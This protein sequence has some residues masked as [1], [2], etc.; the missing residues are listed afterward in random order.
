MLPGGHVLD[1]QLLRH[2]STTSASAREE[3]IAQ[4]VDRDSTSGGEAKAVAGLVV[5]RLGVEPSHVIRKKI[6]EA[7]WVWEAVSGEV[8]RV[9]L[10]GLLRRLLPSRERITPKQY[11]EEV[12]AVDERVIEE[13]DAVLS[14]LAEEAT[15]AV[16]AVKVVRGDKPEITTPVMPDSEETYP[17]GAAGAAALIQACVEAD[18]GAPT[19]HEVLEAI[20]SLGLDKSVDASVYAKL[21]SATTE[22]GDVEKLV[23]L[24]INNPACKEMAKSAVKGAEK[25]PVLLSLA[26][27]QHNL[28][29]FRMY[30]ERVG[31]KANDN[32]LFLAC[33]LVLGSDDASKHMRSF[34]QSEIVSRTKAPAAS[35]EDPWLLVNRG[36]ERSIE[37]KAYAALR[38]AL[39]EREADAVGSTAV[40]REIVAAN[41]GL[42][43]WIL[44]ASGAVG[45]DLQGQCMDLLRMV[46]SKSLLHN[47]AV[48][49][50]TGAAVAALGDALAKCEDDRVVGKFADTVVGAAGAGISDDL[51]GVMANAGSRLKPKQLEKLVERATCA[52]LPGPGA[53]RFLTHADGISVKVLAS[54]L[55][56]LISGG[57]A[58]NAVLAGEALFQQTTELSAT[59]R[60]VARK[61]LV[62]P[63]CGLLSG[64]K[65][66][67][68]AL[69][70]VC[71]SILGNVCQKADLAIVK[72]VVLR[73]AANKQQLSAALGL[74]GAI[75]TVDLLRETL[76]QIKAPL[77]GPQIEQLKTIVK[78]IV[79]EGNSAAEVLDALLSAPQES[80]RLP[81]SV[82]CELARGLNA[83]GAA[84]VLL[85]AADAPREDVETWISGDVLPLDITAMTQALETARALFK[86]ESTFVSTAAVQYHTVS[87]RVVSAVV[88]TLMNLGAPEGTPEQYA[89]LLLA[90]HSVTG[91]AKSKKAAQ[92]R[93][94]AIEAAGALLLALDADRIIATLTALIKDPS[95]QPALFTQMADAIE[96]SA[97]G[98]W[99]QQ[100]LSIPAPMQEECIDA[101]IERASRE[102][103]VMADSLWSVLRGLCSALS[104]AA[105]KD[106]VTKLVGSSEPLA[107]GELPLANAQLCRATTILV[108]RMGASSLSYL[109]VLLPSLIAVLSVKGKDSAQL[110]P[111]AQCL[112][113][114]TGACGQYFGPETKSVFRLCVSP[115]WELTPIGEALSESSKDLSHLLQ[116]TAQRLARSQPVATMMESVKS[117]IIE[118][119]GPK[120]AAPSDKDIFR[121]QKLMS[122]LGYLFS[123][124]S[125]DIR[126]MSAI[127]D[128]L[129]RLLSRVVAVVQSTHVVVPP[130]RR[131]VRWCDAEFGWG[132]EALAGLTVQALSE[133]CLHMRLA[134]VGAVIKTLGK[135]MKRG[136]W[137]SEDGHKAPQTA[138]WLTLAAEL[139]N[140]G[141]Q[142]IG[143]AVLQLM[144]GEILEVFKKCNEQASA[145]KKSSKKRKSGEE[146]AQESRPW[147]FDL[148]QEALNLVA[149]VSNVTSEVSSDG[150]TFEAIIDAV[151]NCSASAKYWPPAYTAE[152]QSALSLAVIAIG[153][154]CATDNQVKY[155]LSDLLR[156]CRMEPSAQVKLALLRAV[157]E[158]WKA[159][160]GPLLVGMSEVS[161]YAGELLE[162]ENAEVERATRL[163]LAEVEAVSGESLLEKIINSDASAAELS[164]SVYVPSFTTTHASPFSL[165]SSVPI[166]GS[167]PGLSPATY[168]P[169]LHWQELPA[170][171]SLH[172]RPE[173]G[174]W[175]CAIG[176]FW[177]VPML[178]PLGMNWKYSVL[179]GNVGR[180]DSLLEM[181]EGEHSREAAIARSCSESRPALDSLPVP[182][183]VASN[184]SCTDGLES[185]SVI[186]NAIMVYKP[187][188]CHVDFLHLKD[189]CVRPPTL[190]PRPETEL[191]VERILESRPPATRL[192]L[193]L[194]SGS[195][196]IGIAL[197]T[198]WADSRVDLVDASE[199]AMSLA[200]ENA[201]RYGVD[202]RLSF[203]VGAIGD[204][205]FA[206]NSYDMIVSNP[207]YIPTATIEN[208]SRTVKNHEDI[209]ALDGGVKGMDIM[210]QVLDVASVALKPG[211][212]LWMEVYAE[213]EQHGLVEEYIARYHATR[214][215][216]QEVVPDLR[217]MPRF[218]VIRKAGP[219]RAQ[220]DR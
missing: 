1:A 2:L 83:N 29:A 22:D 175:R 214:L 127:H 153:K 201:V 140:R 218:V 6:L 190:I 41:G 157:T 210:R 72:P 25:R 205:E 114:I 106:R 73:A 170:G 219:D 120:H 121:L 129:A 130:A 74:C 84:L 215:H 63:L 53:V 149:A 220:R 172:S 199:R 10:E 118:A 141:G 192:A 90:L 3:A 136:G 82:I 56:P 46:D 189:F 163:M 34:A 116:M 94:R 92:T 165:G 66:R 40:V 24:M 166:M 134:D 35:N 186:P 60:E 193:D 155:L 207:P 203:L 108:K 112:F 187:P 33:L 50:A 209:L 138:I 213:A 44:E 70:L 14:L 144:S 99:Q 42:I 18:S 161:V 69:D 17:G 39:A 47:G 115:E 67:E 160:G 202:E 100:Y 20:E 151:A 174:E 77:E 142:E 58:V 4:L 211:G 156:P 217:D 105:L 7:E 79:G 65:A 86:G 21:A 75:K 125:A 188:E 9:A 184:A 113:E 26:V 119:C 71:L 162:D 52:T 13:V 181:V 57:E 23:G 212:L 133:A 81:S 85:L 185:A 78:S 110:Q 104:L 180:G 38:K 122:L 200:R 32:A 154:R 159:V 147:W 61:A 76:G 27:R 103:A 91:N 195:G 107:S 45:A 169:V 117:L 28:K 171:S 168:L 135:A 31:S 19:A 143:V 96:E 194:C 16:I 102:D 37:G 15:A 182:C 132:S 198:E 87:T 148:M 36:V 177:A 64:E 123:R 158:L 179:A 131:E 178:A 11:W 196:V 101:V 95:K 54:T 146:A 111:T 208:L 204:Q 183:G 191:M 12:V 173:E 152:A 176:G 124:T 80:A 150:E 139:C 98:S 5:E 68:E 89:S 206:E 109:S 62:K 97:T 49:S 88:L 167:C 128:P 48:P 216:L 126:V 8:K 55:L 164:T 137:L 59:D 93:S 145:S 30:T 197:A 51:L 43:R